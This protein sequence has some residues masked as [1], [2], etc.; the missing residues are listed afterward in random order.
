MCFCGEYKAPVELRN[1]DRQHDA[2]GS[3]SPR[4]L[5]SW[6]KQKLGLLWWI[7]KT[8]CLR[9]VGV[10]QGRHRWVEIAVRKIL[11]LLQ[12][13]LGK[14]PSPPEPQFPSVYDGRDSTSPPPPPP[15][16]ALCP[17]DE[18]QSWSDRAP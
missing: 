16:K 6:E 18:N 4:L 7:M 11:G 1:P 5:S 15:I 3:E 2:Y 13:R 9:R 8:A 14:V 10:G 12:Y 17:D